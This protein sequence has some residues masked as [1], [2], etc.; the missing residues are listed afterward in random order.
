M[1]YPNEERCPC[2]GRLENERAAALAAPSRRK[3]ASENP[4]V[5]VK[6]ATQSPG[7]VQRMVRC[8][9]TGAEAEHV[10]WLIKSNEMEGWY[11]GN[12]EQYWKRSERIKA[13]I[14]GA[15]NGKVSD[16]RH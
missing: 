1:S 7:S 14:A 10:W 3:P 6:S 2:C 4:Q 15:P 11:C 5:L 8:T 16:E 9:F 13:K 12:R